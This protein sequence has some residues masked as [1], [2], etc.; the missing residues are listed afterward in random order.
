MMIWWVRKQQENTIKK[1]DEREWEW[2]AYYN[3]IV[4]III[5]YRLY[6]YIVYVINTPI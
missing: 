2:D 1:W 3:L 5:G 4:N 6:N